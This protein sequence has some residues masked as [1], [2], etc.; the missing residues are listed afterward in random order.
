V[1]TSLITPNMPGFDTE[2]RYPLRGDLRTARKLAGGRKA[3]AVV[4]MFDDKSAFSTALREQLAAIGIRMKVLPALNADFGPGGKLFEKA[5]RS[6]LIWGGEGLET[7]DLASYLER[8]YL[9]PK[10]EAEV[11]R[12]LKLPIPERDERALALARRVE[13]QSLFAVYDSRAF[14]ELVSRRLGCVVHQPMYPGVDLAALCL[15]DQRD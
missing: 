13:R 12:I 5:S 3:T 6:D 10:E 14:P 11:A 15:K 8:L 1:A 4:Y 7:G 9:F 2:P